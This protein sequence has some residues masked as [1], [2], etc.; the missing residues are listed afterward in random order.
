MP[1]AATTPQSPDTPRH[2]IF[3]SPWFRWLE[4]SLGTVSPMGN[5]P[6]LR[7]QHFPWVPPLEANWQLIR[8]ELEQVLRQ[9]EA[10]PNF[11]DIMPRQQR[12]SPDSGWKTYYFCA[13]GFVARHNCQ[14]CPQTWKLLQQIPG[15]QVAFFSILAPG[16]HIPEHRGK[17]KGL[18]RYH[19]G[20][21]VPQPAT[22]CRIRVGN[23][24]THWQEGQSLIFD[25]TYYHEVWNDTD[26]YR[27]VL[28]LDIAR[29]LPLPLSWLNW[30]IS[31]LLSFSPLVK[32]AKANHHHWEQQF[33]KVSAQPTQQPEDAL[34]QR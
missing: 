5:A 27:V 29:P 19:L 3:D 22:A 21:I 8:Q 33:A 32:Q 11:Q 18:I 20:L 9:V 10:L 1:T 14:Q 25:D 23:Q 30:L 2:P 7:S 34:G 28:F 17:H 13:F 26:G 31:R 24:I 6:I 12:I 15:L 4:A 16:K